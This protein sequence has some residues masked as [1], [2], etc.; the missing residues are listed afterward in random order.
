MGGETWQCERMAMASSGPSPR[1]RG[2]PRRKTAW[3]SA[4]GSIP[5]WAGK[6]CTSLA[7]PSAGRVH[8]RV[9]GET[10]IGPITLVYAG[11]PSPRGRGNLLRRLGGNVLDRSIPAW[12]G[13]P[14]GPSSPETRSTVHPRVGG[15]TSG[16]VS[17]NVPSLGPSP[18]GRG[19]R[20]VLDAEVKRMGSIPAWAGKPRRWRAATKAWEVH[21]RVGGETLHAAEHRGGADGPSP[22]GRGN[23]GSCGVSMGVDRSIPAWAGKPVHRESPLPG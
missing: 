16:A 22:R 23:P 8:P 10:E 13:K 12:A 14:Q 7:Q 11:G 19:N 2:N 1:G 15:E 5:A 9:G 6:P 21:P 17:V 3:G 20:G 18:R 4:R